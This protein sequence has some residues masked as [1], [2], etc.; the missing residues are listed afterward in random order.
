MTLTNKIQRKICKHFGHKFQ[1]YFSA[2]SIDL[3]IRV[4]TRCNEVQ[5]LEKPFPQ[6]KVWIGLVGL[7]KKGAKEK[8]PEWEKV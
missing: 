1:Y 2:M 6:K 4:C 5:R 3:K 7:T 8:V